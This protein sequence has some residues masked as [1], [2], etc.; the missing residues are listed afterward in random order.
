MGKEHNQWD[1]KIT[2][3]QTPKFSSFQFFVR[4]SLEMLLR[5]FLFNAAL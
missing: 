2:E 4:A 1:L 5:T 3:F